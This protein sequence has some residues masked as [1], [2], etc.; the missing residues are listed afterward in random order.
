[1]AP[2]LQ[3]C[4]HSE[5]PVQVSSSIFTLWRPL[6]SASV[7]ESD[8]QPSFM[9]C[10]QAL[11]TSSSTVKASSPP[12]LRGKSMQGRLVMMTAGPS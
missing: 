12:I 4:S 2:G 9:H 10:W 11:Q 1:M 6:C 5:Q 8:G 3:S 7:C